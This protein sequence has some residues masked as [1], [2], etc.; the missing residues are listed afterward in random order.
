MKG[1]FHVPLGLEHKSHN[2]IK[3]LKQS[4]EYICI[5]LGL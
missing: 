3:S 4:T 5:N 1:E 2:N